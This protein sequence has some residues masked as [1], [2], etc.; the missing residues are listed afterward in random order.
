ME[1]LGNFE[2]VRANVQKN[3]D[4]STVTH[5]TKD[6]SIAPQSLKTGG[7]G[8]D[9]GVDS[10][11]GELRGVLA[12]FALAVISLDVKN[13][14]Y[15]LHEIFM[16]RFTCINLQVFDDSATLTMRTSVDTE[17][18]LGATGD[19]VSDPDFISQVCLICYDLESL[20]SCSQKDFAL[21]AEA[22]YR[23]VANA[24]AEIVGTVIFRG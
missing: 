14:F 17:S 4:C 6:A 5:G 18:K 24:V 1:V 22:E 3:R 16:R 8:A 2:N 13:A 11:R 9:V 10:E 23:S 19:V 21:Y 20:I 7:F 15:F 12:A